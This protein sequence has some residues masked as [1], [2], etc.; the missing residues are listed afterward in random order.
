MGERPDAH[1]QGERLG[2]LISDVARSTNDCGAHLLQHAT[3]IRRRER[4]W[5]L[6]NY[7]VPSTPA[8]PCEHA[9]QPEKGDRHGIR[10][11]VPTPPMHVHTCVDGSSAKE[12]EPQD[13]ELSHATIMALD[14]STSQCRCG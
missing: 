5:P 12:D 6:A 4:G 11:P 7:R 1:R 14:I 10:P 9:E 8:H 13:Q 3:D 2:W